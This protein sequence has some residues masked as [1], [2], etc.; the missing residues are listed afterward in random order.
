MHLLAGKPTYVALQDCVEVLGLPLTRCVILG[1]L[2]NLYEPQFCQNIEVI[3]ID[4]TG[5]YED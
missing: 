1:K 5:D 3:I 2:L 4:V